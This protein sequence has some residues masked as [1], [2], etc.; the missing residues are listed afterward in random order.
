MEI[1]TFA[2][3]NKKGKSEFRLKKKLALTNVL[4]LSYLKKNT[5]TNLPKWTMIWRVFELEREHFKH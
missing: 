2:G 3:D 5:Q 1:T 4:R